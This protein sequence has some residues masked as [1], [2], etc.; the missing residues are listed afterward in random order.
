MRQENTERN[1]Y[2]PFR[3]ILSLRSA[4]SLVKLFYESFRTGA[5]ARF[6]SKPWTEA[7]WSPR[8]TKLEDELQNAPGLTYVTTAIINLSLLRGGHLLWTLYVL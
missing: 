3:F 2:A 6:P 1:L 5:G 7:T 4:R 8:S